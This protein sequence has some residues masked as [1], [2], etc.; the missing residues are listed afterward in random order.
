MTKAG[1]AGAILRDVDGHFIAA[2]CCFIPHVAT[3]MMAEAIAPREGL[4]LA[5]RQ[6][7]SRVQAES[8]FSDVIDACNG[9][10]RW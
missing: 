1:V 4:E 7:L 2:S 3:L 10:E 5:T 9:D 6:S 8:E